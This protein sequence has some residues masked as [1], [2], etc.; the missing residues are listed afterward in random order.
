MCWCVPVIEARPEISRQDRR[1]TA[2]FG[3]A[4]NAAGEGE[5][6][7]ETAGQSVLE[8]HLP[9]G[10]QHRHARADSAV[11]V[12]ERSTLPGWIATAAPARRPSVVS[13][14]GPAKRQKEK[15]FQSGFS[16]VMESECGI[17]RVG[18]PYTEPRNVMRLVR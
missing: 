4:E 15:W 8:G 2:D 13:S 9:T 14:T 18:D 17:G 1:M 16:G 6:I 11:P 5:P 10:V 3:G 12:G 7:S